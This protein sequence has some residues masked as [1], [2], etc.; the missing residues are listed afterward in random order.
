MRKLT[1]LAAL[2]PC[3]LGCGSRGLGPRTAAPRIQVACTVQPQ[4]ALVHVA[5]ARGYFAAEGLEVRPTLHGFG[6][7][8]LQDMLEGRA[9]FATVAETP[10][11]FSA[12]K[13]DDL[14]VVAGVEAS[15]LNNAI[16]ARRSAGVAVPA[17]LRGKRVAFTPGTTSE[18]FLDSILTTLGLTRRDLV[19]VPCRPEDM[20]DALV[21]RRV[22]AASCWNYPLA[23][24]RR[25]L[26]TDAFLI[27]DREIY[28]EI[29]TLVAPRSFINAN[30]GVVRRFLRALLR[31][32][33]DVARDPAGAQAVVSRAS[34][35]PLEL[36]KEVWGAFDHRLGLDQGL[37]VALEDETRWAMKN[38]L[39]PGGPMPD[40]RKLLYPDGLRAVAPTAV[41]L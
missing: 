39:V 25:A 16:I 32:E 23:G 3:L 17:A 11:M 8:A 26:G 27:Q 28:T 4:S 24:I 18:F 33:K 20:Q 38:G 15:T 12:L 7:A 21:S 1:V 36:V 19:A 5:L 34:G 41:K 14:Q 30:P 31:A 13:G 6:K 29:F 35:A 37:L 9:Q 10:I 22:D 2:L 40:Y